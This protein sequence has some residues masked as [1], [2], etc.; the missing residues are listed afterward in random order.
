MC[1]NKKKKKK[2]KKK[3][4]FTAATQILYNCTHHLVAR[5]SLSESLS[6]SETIAISLS[7]KQFI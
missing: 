1:L 2:K 5:S 4:N 6:F 7:E 3:N